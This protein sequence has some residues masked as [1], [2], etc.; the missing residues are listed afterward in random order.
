MK[1]DALEPLHQSMQANDIDR[2]RFGY[3][4]GKAKFDVFFLADTQPYKLIFGVYDQN[5]FIEYDVDKDFRINPQLSKEHYKQLCQLLELKYDPNNH[6]SPGAFMAD[7]N[8]YIPKCAHCAQKVQP[9]EIIRYRNNI[10]EVEK[11]WFCGWRDNAQRGQSVTAEN[12]FK[13]R[14]LL[15]ERAYQLCKERNVSSCWTDDRSRLVDVV[16]PL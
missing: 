7:F 2:Y 8:T 16:I 13:T 15:G 12:L 11:I 14:Q 1:L 10:E 4:H 9:H 3:T 6:F 5:V